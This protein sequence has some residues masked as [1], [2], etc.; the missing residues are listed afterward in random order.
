MRGFLSPYL[1]CKLLLGQFGHRLQVVRPD[2][3]YWLMGTVKR[4]ID[5]GG[6]T[7]NGVRYNGAVLHRIRNTISPATRTTKWQVHI[8]WNDLRFCY[9][10]RNQGLDAPPDWVAVPWTNAPK[11]LAIP[12][13]EALRDFLRRNEARLDANGTP[14]KWQVPSDR[15]GD[16]VS[17]ESKR[18]GNQMRL[19]VRYIADLEIHRR[20]PNFLESEVA[21]VTFALMEAARASVRWFAAQEAWRDADP[22]ADEPEGAVS[23]AP[24]PR[25]ARRRPL[26]GR[27][28]LPRKLI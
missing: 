8:D 26:Q 7:I 24:E 3:R 20:T 11:H 9:V 6:I 2:L 21:D 19:Y 16:V 25:A 15:R 28:G 23:T 27:N 1:A 10:N 22:D 18:L 13:P 5:D 4:V 14:I 12:F 17:D